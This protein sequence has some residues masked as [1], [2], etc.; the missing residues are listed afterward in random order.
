MANLSALLAVSEPSGFWITIIKAFEAVTNNYVL[1]IIFLTVVIRVIWAIVDTFSKHSQQ[2][3]SIIQSQMQP[4]LDK[5]KAKYGNSP[6]QLNQKQNEVYKKYYGKS[7]YTGCLMMLVVMIL[8]LVIFFTLFSGLNAMATYKIDSN[9]NNLKYSYANCINVVDDYFNSDYTDESKQELF[10]N[11]ENLAFIIESDDEGKQIISLIKY[12]TNG[13]GEFILDENGNKT[14][15]KVHSL[16]Y[17]TDFGYI[18]EETKEEDGKI[19]VDKTAVTTNDYI[20]SILNRIFPV[21]GEGEVEGSKEI[22]LIEDY[23]PVLDENGQQV[24]GEDGQPVYEDLYLSTAIQST[25]MSYV[26]DVYDQ[27]QDSFLWIEN[28]WIADSP[29][30]KS[31]V[32]YDTLVSQIGGEGNVQ[33]GERQVYDA[34]MKDLKIERSRVNGYYILAILCV[35]VAVASMLLNNYFTKRRNKKQGKEI[36]TQK[37]A[38]WMQIIVPILLGI[39][40]LFYNS[41]FSIYMLTGQIVSAILT[42]LQYLVIDAINNRKNKKTDD[43]KPVV[44]YSRKF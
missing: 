28:I 4:E 27:T 31:I 37:S 36:Q 21:Y 39:F 33:E 42:P 17:K 12:Q 41:V 11:Y 1:A 38:K 32:D 14:F 3:M 20:I 29:T 9:Y 40:A 22:I 13:D 30:V 44:E 43:K 10:K 24:I 19:I 5:I 35:L 25:A 8:N 34:F 23:K 26:I 18:L 16:E 2:K 6:Q 15:S 7:Y